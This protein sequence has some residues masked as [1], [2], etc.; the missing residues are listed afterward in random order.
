M[1]LGEQ[2]W[3][4]EL[5]VRRRLIVRL[6]VEVNVI[7]M[8]LTRAWCQRF[9]HK[10]RRVEYGLILADLYGVSEGRACARK[11]CLYDSNLDSINAPWALRMRAD[12]ER[13]ISGA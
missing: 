6:Q 10:F 13:L 4:L 12:R 11:W 5:P 1:S 7:K 3:F 8:R 2:P 9:G